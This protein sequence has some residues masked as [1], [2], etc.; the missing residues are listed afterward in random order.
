MS[1]RVRAGKRDRVR[2]RMRERERENERK[3]ERERERESPKKERV[4]RKRELINA[5]GLVS[6]LALG[7]CPTA[8]P[9]F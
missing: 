7:A 6:V 2:A 4:Q 3:R 1:A 8:P 5:F 9:F